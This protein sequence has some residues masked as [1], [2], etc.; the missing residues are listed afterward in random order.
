MLFLPQKFLKSL[1]SIISLVSL[2]L[3]VACTEKSNLVVDS[4]NG[5]SYYYHYRD[6]DSTLIYADSALQLAADYPNGKAEALNNLAFVEM[7]AMHYEKAEKYLEEVEDISDSQLELLVADV[8][9]MKLCQKRSRNKDFY[10][11]SERARYRLSRIQDESF[12]LSSHD[13]QRLTYAQSEYYIVSSAYYYYVGLTKQAAGMLDSIDP[14]G[15]IER[16]TAQLLN[17][18]YNIGAGGIL[19]GRDKQKI[20]KEEFDYLVR[21][22]NLS[23]SS[24]LPYW[25]AQALQAMS[26]HLQDS[27]QRQQI[28]ASCYPDIVAVNTDFM[29]DSLLAGNLA[30][31]ALVL[32]SQYGDVYQTAGAY[33]TL[34][35]C[36]WHIGD[37]RSALICLHT[38][39]GEE[40]DSLN[41]KASDLKLVSQAPDLV[42]SIR[43]DLCLAY[44]AIDDKKN[45]DRNRNI[46][47]DLQEQTRQDRQL[48]AR[49]TQLNSSLRSLNVMIAVV[50]MMIVIV[51]VLLIVFT[52]MRR[53]SDDRFSM[54]ALLKP[55]RQWQRKNVEANKQRQEDFEQIGEETDVVRLH[56]QQN[57]RRNLE[58]RAKVQLVCSILPIIDRMVN[59]VKRLADM[60]QDTKA[61]GLT[62]DNR[63]TPTVAARRLE[64]IGELTD[65]INEYN[66]ILTQWIQMRQGELSI[67]VENFPVQSLFDIVA[68]SAMSFRLKGINLV[69]KPTQSVVKAD[70]IL[71]LFMINTIADNARKFTQKDGTV[72][73][74][75]S[76]GQSS[77]PDAQRYAEI[78]VTDNGKGMDAE[79]L[80]HI[81]DRTYTGGHGFG[82][83]NCKGIIE[84]YKKLSR[85]FNVCMI[86]A[87][88][89][90]GKGT[91]IFFRLPIGRLRMIVIGLMSTLLMSLPAHAVTSSSRS[92]AAVFADSA[93]LSNVMG[94]YRRTLQYADSCRKYL[95]PSD[96]TILLDVSNEAAVAALA[97]HEWSVY[98]Q[99][100]DVYTRLFREASADSTLPTYVNT[101]QRSKTNKTISVVLLIMMLMIVFPAY[102]F[103]YYRHKLNY[104][105]C[106]D[107]INKMN[108]ILLSDKLQSEKLRE[109]K[110]LDDFHRFNLTPEQKESLRKVVSQ[111][112]DALRQSIE[113]EN[114]LEAKAELM[115]DEYRR[116]EL[117]TDRLHISN[118][119]LDNCLS[120]LKHETMY[121]PSRIRQ[122][123]DREGSDI[124]AVSE[125]V[126]YYHDLYSILA[127]QS[128]RQVLPQRIDQ[129]TVS[130]LFEILTKTSYPLAGSSHNPNDNVASSGHKTLPYKVENAGD[131]YA[132][133][134]VALPHLQLTD[135]QLSALFTPTTVNLDFLLCRQIVREM[136]EATNLRACG[137]SAERGADGKVEVKIL[138]PKRFINL[139]PQITNLKQDERL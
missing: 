36:Y 55:L 96:T 102:Y 27:V 43:E 4:L 39:L 61:D 99:N 101:M 81:F 51:T 56:L 134:T 65:S 45:S 127:E 86:D 48:E 34:A 83:K 74:E 63:H 59:E 119:I 111:I 68:H 136:G 28:V 72:T 115:R 80:S 1:Y 132:R 35:E 5:R 110:E 105:F 124:N 33:R 54:T 30:Q 117:E 85:L 128:L 29:P 8:Q 37:Y 14:Y 20:L 23:S 106:V 46:Y 75:C 40:A 120:T 84:K 50:A 26:E 82:L 52:R 62:A 53:R 64:Y 19:M 87:K 69:V 131:G 139:K 58:Q 2:L 78:S 66:D 10:V 3:L 108:A 94:N 118:S 122:M 17:Y 18:W 13:Q 107:R 130:Y 32:F 9:Q 12:A 114:E 70:R 42:A 89:E 129:E 91:R 138:M 103:L 49:A 47:L 41:H 67:R 6:L 11:Y 79:T 113:N 15:S 77:L 98:R 7:A 100:N 104:K 135:E 121:Y 57:K 116:L 21:C 16:D 24:G 126:N 137:I 25:E 90:T 38:A 22:Y 133:V 95:S 76:E 73:I 92:T 44:S 123:I 97:L 60:Q 71:T 112:E 93:Y 109:I 88:S 31:R 125:V